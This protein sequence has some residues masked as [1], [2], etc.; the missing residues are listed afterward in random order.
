MQYSN[1]E[2][3]TLLSDF[4]QQKLELVPQSHQLWRP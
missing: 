3:L 1:T 4:I 2:K